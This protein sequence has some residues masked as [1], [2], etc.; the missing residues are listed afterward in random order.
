MIENN[1]ENYLNREVK[2]LGGRAAKFVSPGLRGVPDRIVL[3]PGGKMV[4]IE[5]KAP[6]EKPRKQQMYRMKQIEDLGFKT[7]TIDSYEAVKEFIRRELGG[8]AL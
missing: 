1:V 8:D 5:L 6:G 7:Y 2:K 3:L 4:F